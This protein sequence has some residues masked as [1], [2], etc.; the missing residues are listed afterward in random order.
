MT[1]A[2]HA[3]AI[4]AAFERV[5]CGNG[6]D[7]NDKLGHV[8]VGKLH[9]LIADTIEAVVHQAKAEA[10]EEMLRPE[11]DVMIGGEG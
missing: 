5:R 2:E 9:R 1:A 11:P 4:I 3:D 7:P 8:R 10:A 6:L